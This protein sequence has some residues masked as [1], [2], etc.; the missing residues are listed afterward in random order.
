MLSFALNFQIS[1]Y[2]H[3]SNSHHHCNVN[4]SK[5][6]LCFTKANTIFFSP[7]STT[8]KLFFQLL[9]QDDELLSTPNNISSKVIIEI[10]D[11]LHQMLFFGRYR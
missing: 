6:C 7:S 11:L 9:L 4:V 2:L 8:N 3:T 10:M 5:F 1:V